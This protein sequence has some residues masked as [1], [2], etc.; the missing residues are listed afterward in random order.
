V[1]REPGRFDMIAELMLAVIAAIGI[2]K[3]ERRYA[4]E[5]FKKYIAFAF[6]A[7]LILEYNSW[8]SPRRQ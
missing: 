3:L 6:L 2:V 4:H 1:L 7:L 5:D 8:P